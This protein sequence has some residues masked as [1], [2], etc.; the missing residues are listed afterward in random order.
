MKIV[1]AGGSGF[2]GRPLAVALA[3]RRPRRRHPHPRRRTRRRGPTRP[4]APSRWTPNGDAGRLGDARSTAPTPSST[5]P[6]NRSR[7]DAGPTHRSGG[8]STAACRRRAASRQR[9]CTPPR[10]PAVLRQRIGGRLLRPARRRDRDRR[11]AARIRFPR[12]RL[13]AVGSRG[14]P[15]AVGDRTRVV[16][17]RTGLVLEQDGG[18]LPQM[19]PPFKF[20]AGGPVGSGRQYWPWIHRDDWIALVRWA[21]GQRR[22]LGRRQCDGAEPGDQRRLRRARSAARIHRPAFCPRRRSRCAS[23][24][25]K[26]RTRCCSPVSA[27]FLR[28]RSINGSR[29]STRTSR[30]RFRRFSAARRVRE[31]ESA[32]A[33]IWSVHPSTPTRR[34]QA[35]S[36]SAVESKNADHGRGRVLDFAAHDGSSSDARV[37]AMPAQ[38]PG[39][40][41]RPVGQLAALVYLQPMPSSV[42]TPQHPP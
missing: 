31:Y 42:R 38:R 3:A 26:W 18:A 33:G 30:P 23:C 41:G 15:R 37:S 25:A 7:R 14:E 24:S 34:G 19:L 13:R 5:S 6:A 10:P 29:S 4:R 40:R 2:L 39:R 35:G 17:I 12:A 9:S 36:G 21:I 11:H 20:G 8:S 28:R 16:C 1:I 32:I 27:P 22:Q